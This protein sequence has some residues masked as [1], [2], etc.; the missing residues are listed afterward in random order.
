M[1]P[2]L[3]PAV[4]PCPAM[5]RGV[6]FHLKESTCKTTRQDPELLLCMALLEVHQGAVDPRGYVYKIEVGPFV[7]ETLGYL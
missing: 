7:V 3:S 2:G 1:A 4:P 6:A 5:R